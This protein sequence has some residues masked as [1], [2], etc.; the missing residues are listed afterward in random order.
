M[1]IHIHEY[2]VDSRKKNSRE[3]PERH[4]YGSSCLF[5]IVMITKAAPARPPQGV[6]MCAHLCKCTW[7]KQIKKFNQ[8]VIGGRTEEVMV[9]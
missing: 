9:A 2:Y 4:S 8:D 3:R 5:G 1:H 6:S 7:L